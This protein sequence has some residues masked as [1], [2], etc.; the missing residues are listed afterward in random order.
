MPESSNKPQF[1]N[2]LR[3]YRDRACLTRRQ[4]SALSAR[5]SESDPVQYTYVGPTTIQNLE[6]GLSQPRVSTARTLS[7]LLGT[8]PK[9]V[10]PSGLDVKSR[11]K[12]RTV[13]SA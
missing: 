12:S 7:H 4:L 13:N 8:D 6:R 1:P 3:A 11:Y 5:L 10:F 9:N 2:E